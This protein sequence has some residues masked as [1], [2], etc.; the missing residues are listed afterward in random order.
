MAAYN[1]QKRLKRR[2]KNRIIALFVCVYILLSILFLVA[3]WVYTKISHE[4]IITST[5]SNLSQASYYIAL[6][7]GQA[8]ATAQYISQKT[9]VA[10]FANIENPTTFQKYI[11][12]ESIR[13]DIIQ[14]SELNT[15]IESIFVYFENADIISTSTYGNYLMEV[16]EDTAVY[17]AIKSP[18]S[19]IGNLRYI[20]DD[21]ISKKG[22]VSFIIKGNTYNVEIHSNVILMINFNEET[23]YNIIKDIK[24]TNPSMPILLSPDGKILSCDNKD[25]LGSQFVI[26]D[27]EISKNPKGYSK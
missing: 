14:L 5:K 8:R 9:E 18:S 22:I 23:I 27:K 6:L 2:L 24:S 17:E 19:Y 7:V 4:K 13:Q 21:F 16:L 12:L 3:S 10:R 20:N 1:H 11:A 26:E 15:N 25:F